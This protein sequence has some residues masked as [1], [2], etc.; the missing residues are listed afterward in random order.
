MKKL[1]VLVALIC[2]LSLPALAQEIEKKEAE[3]NVDFVASIARLILQPVPEILSRTAFAAIT[4]AFTIPVAAVHSVFVPDTHYYDY[5]TMQYAEPLVKTPAGKLPM[6]DL[7]APKRTII[8][9]QQ[10]I[11][12]LPAEK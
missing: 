12:P 1:A 11:L 3:R 9:I 2:L 8:G 7:P 6:L 4:E 10:N 5:N